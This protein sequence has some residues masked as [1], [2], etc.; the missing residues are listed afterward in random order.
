MIQKYSDKSKEPTPKLHPKYHLQPNVKPPLRRFI[1]ISHF[2]LAIKIEFPIWMG[3][4]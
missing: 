1:E 4:T 3:P 2:H